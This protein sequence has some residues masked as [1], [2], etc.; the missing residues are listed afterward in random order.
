MTHSIDA[1]VRLLVIGASLVLVA[2][3]AAGQMRPGLRG[4]A[5][6]LF[7]ALV[8]A[9]LDGGGLLPAATLADPWIGLAAISAPLWLW[10]FTLRL[11]GQGPQRRVVLVALAA[12]WGAWIIATFAGAGGEP[13]F[14]AARVLALA[15]VA[16][17]VRAAA[18]AWRGDPLPERRAVRP[19]LAGFAV[20]QAGVPLA[21]EIA[22]GSARLPGWLALAQAVVS[23]ALVLF[24]ALA[25]TRT[26]PALVGPAP[27]GD[28]LQSG[29]GG[30]R[31]PWS[32]EPP[33][34]PGKGD[35]S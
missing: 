15:L 31:G 7:A 3:L 29:R 28:P 18:V 12:L 9:M 17:I 4:P 6:A 1:L 5:L 30:V 23:L 35:R 26:D 16:D 10:L 27:A 11:F 32:P 2:S 24:L 8:A 20:L 34:E 13:A 33:G 19:W 21:V 22:A 14:Y 25:L